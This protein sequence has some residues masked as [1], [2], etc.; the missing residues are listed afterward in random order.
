MCLILGLAQW[1]EGPCVTTA[2]AAQIQ[3]LALER[4]N[5]VGTTT[6]KKKMLKETEDNSKKDIREFPSWRSG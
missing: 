3:S 4:P 1:V 2:A 5:T 6:E